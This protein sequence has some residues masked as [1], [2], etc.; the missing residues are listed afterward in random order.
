MLPLLILYGDA[1][2]SAESDDA[3]PEGVD[4]CEEEEEEG[5]NVTKN[6]GTNVVLQHGH[7]VVYILWFP[8]G[9]R[10]KVSLR[11]RG[12]PRVH[13]RPGHFMPSGC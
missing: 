7:A 3:D 12:R 9:M 4:R 8:K 2:L 1:L 10:I 5:V 6:R 13:L 11:V